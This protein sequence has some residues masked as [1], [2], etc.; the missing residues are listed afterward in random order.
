MLGDPARAVSH[1]HAAL[2]VAADDPT[3]LAALARIHQ[4]SA[5]WPAAA[6][7]LRRLVAAPALDAAARVGHLLALAEIRAEAF[8]DA[9]AALDLCQQAR[10]LAPQDPAVLEALGR[11]AERGG[12]PPVVADTLAA[13]AAAA[14]PGP[15][16]ARAHLRAA[17]VLAGAGDAPAVVAEL[18]RALSADPGLVEARAELAEACAA[19]DP[20]RAMEEHRC[21]LGEEPARVG[22]WRALFRLAQASRAYDHAFVAACVLRFL[23]ASDVRTDGAF[24]AVKALKAPLAPARPLAE[25]DWLA[26][27][28]PG[29]RCPLSDVLALAGDALAEV[30][31][32]PAPTR[33]RGRAP[34]AL[35][36]ILGELCATVGVAPP[37]LRPGG[38]GAEL[39]LAPGHPAI[40]YVGAELAQRQTPAEQRFLLARAAARLRAG[41]ALAARLSPEALRE[42]LAATLRQ[43]APADET[44][45]SAREAVVKAVGR[46]L[47][48]KVR[49][50]LEEPARAVMTAGPPDFDAWQAAL[51]ATANRA[52]LLLSADVPAA[53]KVVLREVGPKVSGAAEVAAAVGARADLRDLLVFVASGEHLRLR[54]RLGLAL[55]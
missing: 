21:L 2:A 10:A 16:R 26:L 34:A 40:V 43:Y 7:A 18:E 3:A 12:A 35:E 54:E 32:L 39:Q 36:Q 50:T 53:L 51:A 24:Q 5:N 14:P 33:E 29:E 47:P 23:Q 17:R 27:R 1:L 11:H 41:S 22:S 30:A 44:L 28:H 52:G 42:L 6:D 49:K 37:A 48:R 38:E 45:G 46:A 15:E 8:A 25:G 4:Q 9:A 19:A 31:Q 13:A 55:P 20:A